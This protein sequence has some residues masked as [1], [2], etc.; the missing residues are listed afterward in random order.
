[1]A[2]TTKNTTNNATKGARAIVKLPRI[3]GKDA[4]Q[5]REFSINGK[6][7]LVETGKNVEVPIEIAKLIEDNEQAEEYALQYADE[8]VQKEKDKGKELGLN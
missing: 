7:Y 1:M 3:S 4:I 2:D 8:L 6:I 5:Q